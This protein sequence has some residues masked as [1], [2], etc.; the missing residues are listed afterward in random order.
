[1][2][3]GYCEHQTLTSLT[4]FR[5]GGGGGRHY[6]AQ[7]H[8]FLLQAGVAWQGLLNRRQLI[9]YSASAHCAAESY[10]DVA[11]RAPR[12]VVPQLRPPLRHP[13]SL[14]TRVSRPSEKLIFV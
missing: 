1:M 7:R 2:Q 5:G 11:G 4:S 6:P 10:L 12:F 3:I 9:K 8:I 14:S 13:F